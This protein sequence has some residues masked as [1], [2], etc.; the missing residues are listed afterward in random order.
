MILLVFSKSMHSSRIRTARALTAFPI[1]L[2][3]GVCLLI[4]L[5]GVCL[6]GGG[7]DHTHPWPGTL[8]TWPDTPIA[9]H[10]TPSQ[11]HTPKGQTYH[12]TPLW[13]D[14]HPQRYGQSAVGAHP[15]GMHSFF[16]C[17]WDGLDFFSCSEIPLKTYPHNFVLQFSKRIVQYCELHC[18]EQSNFHHNL[19]K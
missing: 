14:T 8:P 1:T 16:K 13:P 6:L 3:P 11:T 7:S 19:V 9:R 4:F 18:E 15:T 2:S 12:T 17:Y 5:Q 10:T